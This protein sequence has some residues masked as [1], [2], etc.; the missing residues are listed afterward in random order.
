MSSKYGLQVGGGTVTYFK[1]P[2][3]EQFVQV[4]V[5]PGEGTFY[6]AIEQLG[7]VTLDRSVK[8]WVFSSSDQ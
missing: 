4:F 2:F 3:V 7:D 6:D 5:V 1:I 8:G